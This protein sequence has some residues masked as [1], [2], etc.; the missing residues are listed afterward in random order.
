MENVYSC[1]YGRRLHQAYTP[2]GSGPSCHQ[3]C[4][5]I[6]SPLLFHSAPKR[7][8]VL[9]CCSDVVPP[10]LHLISWLHLCFLDCGNRDVQ[11]GRLL[12]CL[13]EACEMRALKLAHV[14]SSHYS[15]GLGVLAW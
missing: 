14:Q 13:E 8:W 12:P 9:P 3:G 4:L 1:R 11:S 2:Y 7:S 15:C 10:Q 6:L 5:P